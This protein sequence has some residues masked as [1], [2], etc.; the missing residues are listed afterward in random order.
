MDKITTNEIKKTNRA[1]IFTTIYQLGE[2]S[3]QQLAD[4]LQLSMPT[5]TNNLKELLDLN[6]IKREGYYSSSSAGGRKARIIS[7]NRTARIAVGVE[8]LLQNVHIV[9]ADLYGEILAK[10]MLELPFECSGL[11]YCAVGNWVNSFILSLPYPREAILGVAFAI[12]GLVSSDH[13]EVIYGEILGSTGLKLSEFSSH[14]KY[15]C[16]FLHDTEAAAFTEVWNHTEKQD[17]LYLHLNHNFGSALILG[18]KMQSGGGRISG[19]IEHMCLYPDG[20]PCY[21][22]RKGCV[23][24]YCSLNALKQEAGIEHIQDFF[25]KLRKGDAAFLKIW[26]RYLYNLAIAINNALHVIDCNVILGSRIRTWLTQEDIEQLQAYMKELDSFAFHSRPV[27][28]GSSSPEIAAV[29]AAL[30]Q[31][32]EFF[33]KDPVFTGDT[34]E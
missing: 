19:T 3:K 18:G 15:P 14:V 6:L 29:G 22:G 9:A 26:K 24:S 17:I 25:E 7:C 32:S 20:R 27:M 34:G 11:Y 1:N 2:T 5:V 16:L 4:V 23:E 13:T 33:E 21:C 30:F 12:Q 10:D 31:I 8:V 28:L